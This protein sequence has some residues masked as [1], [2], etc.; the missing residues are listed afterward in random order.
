MQADRRDRAGA[1]ERR[2]ANVPF[3]RALDAADCAAGDRNHQG[4]EQ[5][6]SDRAQLACKLQVVVVRVGEI[7]LDD[8]GLVLEKGGAVRTKAAAKQRVGLQ[9]SQRVSPNRHAAFTAGQAARVD[10]AFEIAGQ[11]GACEENERQGARDDQRRQDH[12][13]RGAGHHGRRR[14]RSHH[15]EPEHSGDETHL[16]RR[17]DERSEECQG[18]CDRQGHIHQDC[19]H[20]RGGRRIAGAISPPAGNGV[21]DRQRQSHLEETGKVVPVAVRASHLQAARCL[22]EAAASLHY[23]KHDHWPDGQPRS[24]PKRAACQLSHEQE[25][26]R[27]RSDSHERNRRR[28]CVDAERRESVRRHHRAQGKSDVEPARRQQS[29]EKSGQR[30]E[31]THDVGGRH[32]DECRQ[33]RFQDRSADHPVVPCPIAKR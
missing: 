29:Q 30:H 26:Q 31:L 5:R 18:C 19:P 17:C 32:Q 14:E 4:S 25:G 11:L 1:A 22:Y 3:L 6:K 7:E 13:L 20:G 24:P 33:P 23:P 8:R 27:V 16:R 28:R 15:E 9:E 10:Q 2:K 12:P 21:A